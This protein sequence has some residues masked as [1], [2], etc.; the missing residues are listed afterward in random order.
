[1]S[2]KQE[3]SLKLK[4]LTYRIPYLSLPPFPCILLPLLVT[5]G[6][7]AILGLPI[8]NSSFIQFTFSQ[9]KINDLNSNRKIIYLIF[10]LGSFIRPLTNVVN[11]SW[12]M[13][14]VPF[15]TAI[16]VPI[17]TTPGVVL[18]AG[19]ITSAPSDVFVTKV[20]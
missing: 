20:L 9:C 10:Y 19:S 6:L 16:P 14:I 8:L 4:A 1:M 18:S 12:S 13:E 11:H 2:I 5:P 7:V 17:L 3:V 15:Y